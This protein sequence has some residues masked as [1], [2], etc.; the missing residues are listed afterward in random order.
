MLALRIVIAVAVILAQVWLSPHADATGR[1][2]CT[3]NGC[4]FVEDPPAVQKAPPAFAKYAWQ[5]NA[6]DKDMVLLRRDGKIIG[7]WY[8]PNQM[9]YPFAGGK[10]LAATKPPIDPPGRG[11]QATETLAPW[12]TSGV[13]L[14]R[15]N[16]KLEVVTY[17]GKTI[18]AEQLSAAIAGT[19]DDDSA[20]GYFT[21]LCA[22][23]RQ[24]AAILAE[25]AKLPA[26]FRSRYNVWASAPDH[27]S[28]MDRFAGKPRFH[29]DSSAWTIVLQAPG[30]ENKGEVLFRR[31]RSAEAVF[32]PQ[33]IK[34][35]LKADPGYKPALDPGSQ[36]PTGTPVPLVV[37][38]GAA[39]VV[40]F[41]LSRS[42]K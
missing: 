34:D 8:R 9:Y 1:Y 32:D 18:P 6:A 7:H 15:V 42:K 5:E 29:M 20:K 39:G 25:W 30:L 4:F 37:W 28:M 13:D 24:R 26:D 22:D 40:L 12:Q 10:N 16:G 33:D 31:P 14:S 41:A 11:A 19:L 3:P 23:Q 21:V 38:L 27:F 17:G 36:P 2:V 35:L